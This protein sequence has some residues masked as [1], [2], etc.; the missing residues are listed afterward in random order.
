MRGKIL[1][2]F[3]IYFDHSTFIICIVDLGSIFKDQ[4]S[5]KKRFRKRKRLAI[6]TQTNRFHM[7]VVGV[8]LTPTVFLF[9]TKVMSVTD[10]SAKHNV[11]L[12]AYPVFI[13]LF[14][15]IQSC[16]EVDR[17]TLISFNGSSK[18]LAGST[19]LRLGYKQ[20]RI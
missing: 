5:K 14:L 18:L 3:E 17:S 13:A 1:N 6:I 8:V 2:I 10:G 15:F 11:L 19:S 12:F 7:P 9:S 20:K 16:H 4:I